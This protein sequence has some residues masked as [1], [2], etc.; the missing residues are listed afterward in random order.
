[1]VLFLSREEIRT[2]ARDD[3]HV[4]RDQ[5]RL[6]NRPRQHLLATVPKVSHGRSS[7]VMWLSS[8]NTDLDLII[9]PVQVARNLN[10]VRP[11]GI[12]PEPGPA[13]DVGAQA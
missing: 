4:A 13:R 2:L 10:G 7:I 11:F 5:R 12:R 3:E 1:M 6:W 9:R 8:C